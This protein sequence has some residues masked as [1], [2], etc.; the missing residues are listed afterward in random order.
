DQAVIISI[1]KQ[2]DTNTLKLTERIDETLAQIEQNLP[3][4]F[5]INTHIFRQAD[6]INLAIDNV[7]EALRD[8]AILVVI[9]LFL[10]LANIRTTV[11]SLTAIPLALIASI[12]V[13]ASFDITISTVRLGGVDIAG[14]GIVD[15]AITDVGRGV[16]RLRAEARRAGA[17]Q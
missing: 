7:I 5:T 6:F 1:K 12:F 2:P 4:G 13:L 17:V 15:D 10:F 14:G 3:E 8:G 11:I 16:R 9:I